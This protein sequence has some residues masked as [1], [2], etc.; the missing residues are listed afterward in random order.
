[1]KTAII[2]QARMTSTR[3]PGKVLMKVLGKPL[4]E[5]Q[6]ERL[7][8]SKLS[9][10]VIV[11]TTTN[12]EDD[13]I[14]DLC[15]SIGVKSFRGSELDVLSRYYFAAQSHNVDN[16]VRVTSD[17][18]LIDPVIIDSVIQVY[19][20]NPHYDYVSNC[21]KRTFPRGM[22]TEIFSFSLLC[23]AYEK[24]T[25]QADREHVT[26]F[27]CRNPNL[28]D[29]YGI[30]NVIDNSALRWTVD[31][32]EDFSLMKTMLELLYPKNNHFTLQDCLDLIK[33]HPSLSLINQHIEQKKE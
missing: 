8:R 30:E 20:R 2:V 24:S 5:Y 27:F 18:P 10:E 11:A 13:A 9:Q 12:S 32:I 33:D 31:T 3:L 6:I 16:I 1:M 29:L 17:C 23:D 19:L 25:S 4:L 15:K 7:A 14:V 22:D 21:L 26:R 28:Y